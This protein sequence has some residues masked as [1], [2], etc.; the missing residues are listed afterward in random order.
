MAL[1]AVSERSG[2]ASHH[3]ADDGG[4]ETAPVRS[5]SKCL[6]IGAQAITVGS[7]QLRRSREAWEVV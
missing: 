1:M 3:L 4:T 7:R 5:R 2:V 6:G